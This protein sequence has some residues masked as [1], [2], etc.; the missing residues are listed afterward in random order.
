MTASQG[1]PPPLLQL[2]RLQ[3]LTQG[4][5]VRP[6]FHTR[7]MALPA[8]HVQV[9]DDSDLRRRLC[10]CVSGP[11]HSNAGRISELLCVSHSPCAVP[12]WSFG[13]YFA[14]NAQYRSDSH[15]LYLR[16]ILSS[17]GSFS[18]L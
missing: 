10:P 4:T 6:T 11:S 17:S 8:G 13:A 15:P 16:R 3:P 5:P 12:C 1:P 9:L 14:I 2:R 7:S 18:T